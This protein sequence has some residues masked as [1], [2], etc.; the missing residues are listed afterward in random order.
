MLP[1]YFWTRKKKKKNHQ[2][3]GSRDA[4]QPSLYNTQLSVN[5]CQFIEAC[6][7]CISILPALHIEPLPPGWQCLAKLH[8]CCTRVAPTPPLHQFN[9]CHRAAVDDGW[10]SARLSCF[11]QTDH[12]SSSRALSGAANVNIPETNTRYLG[13]IRMETPAPSCARFMHS[14]RRHHL[15]CICML[16]LWIRC[17]RVRWRRS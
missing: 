5:D 3:P 9:A 12:A 2:P 8:A 7:I 1:R 13:R 16:G 15:R 14:H 6:H 4:S 10:A 17:Q 11:H